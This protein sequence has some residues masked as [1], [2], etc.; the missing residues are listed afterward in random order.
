MPGKN[1]KEERGKKKEERRKKK[2]ERRKKKKEKREKGEERRKEERENEWR[3]VERRIHSGVIIIVVS[4]SKCSRLLPG[5]RAPR[6]EV[7]GRATSA[8]VGG[9]QDRQASA[10][11]PL[12]LLSAPGSSDPQVAAA[13]CVSLFLDYWRTLIQ[14]EDR[15][16]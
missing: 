9:W 3:K 16:K 2:K 5:G 15:V 12:R 6:V 14:I 1:K 4:L 10:P 8:G 13:A 7:R 11:A